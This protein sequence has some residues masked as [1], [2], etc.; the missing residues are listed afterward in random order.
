MGDA[1]IFFVRSFF[2][3]FFCVTFLELCEAKGFFAFFSD[4]DNDGFVD[5]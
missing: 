2:S 1:C 4:E 3:F 5:V